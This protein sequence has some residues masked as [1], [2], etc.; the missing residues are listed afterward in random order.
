MSLF[1]PV[2]SSANKITDMKTTLVRLAGVISCAVVLAGCSTVDSRIAKNREAFNTWPPAVQ[3][4]VV[5][6]KIDI[7]FTPEQV[8]VA[9]GEPDRVFT[10]T[11]AD[12][13]SQIWSYRDR[14]PRFGFGVGVGM[15]SFG[16]RS[17]SFGGVSVGT[18]GGYRDD[19]KLGVVFD[20]G[21]HVSSIETRGK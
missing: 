17:G 10:R 9:I 11:S 15:G 14:G 1:N 8:R 5:V 19:E 7:G 3:D 12:G 21:G 18:G 2:F 6:G 4:K 20:S 13:T 16:S